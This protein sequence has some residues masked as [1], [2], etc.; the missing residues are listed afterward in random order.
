MNNIYEEAQKEADRKIKKLSED[1]KKDL[2]KIFKE[3]TK[4][5]PEDLSNLSTRELMANA[6]ETNKKYILKIEE[7]MPKHFSQTSI[8]F[9]A[10]ECFDGDKLASMLYLWL[11]NN[12]STNR[13]EVET[14]CGRPMYR[15]LAEVLT[16]L[17]E[18][19]E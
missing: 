3:C 12:F 15:K 14:D 4:K 8:N 6:Y 13:E 2:D 19:Q 5:K 7:E 11:F 1:F 18:V 16:R 9:Y 17:I 10:K